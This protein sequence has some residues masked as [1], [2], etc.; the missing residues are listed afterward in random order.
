MDGLPVDS[1]MHQ[2]SLLLLLWSAPAVAACGAPDSLEFREWFVRQDSVVFEV[3]QPRCDPVPPT[4]HLLAP[5]EPAP[6]GGW[7][8]QVAATPDFDDAVEVAGFGASSRGQD[9]PIPIRQPL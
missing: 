1:C 5:R 9:P 7:L 3:Q 4:L 8:V 6:D 2:L